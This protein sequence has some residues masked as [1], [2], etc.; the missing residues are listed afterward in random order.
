MKSPTNHDLHIMLV[1][2]RGDIKGIAKD[3]E[4]LTIGFASHIENDAVEF[5]NLNGS[6]SDMNR[7]AASIAVVAGGISAC[8]AWIWHRVMG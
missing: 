3:M 7:Y 6:I 4:T 2:M 8:G 5:K 1:E